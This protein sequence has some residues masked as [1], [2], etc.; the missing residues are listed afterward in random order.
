MNEGRGS[1]AHQQGRDRS[2][3]LHN[4]ARSRQEWGSF[5]SQSYYCAELVERR[6]SA[7]VYNRR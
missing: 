5:V 4:A 3:L 2:P 6:V 7:S 1:A